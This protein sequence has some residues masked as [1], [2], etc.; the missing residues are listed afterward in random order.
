MDVLGHDDIDHAELYSREASPGSA[1]GAGWIESCVWWWA[2]RGS[3]LVN[4]NKQLAGD[5]STSSYE[6]ILQQVEVRRDQLPSRNLFVL[7]GS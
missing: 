2:R 1:G 4:E 6:Q 3:H 5:C 7:D